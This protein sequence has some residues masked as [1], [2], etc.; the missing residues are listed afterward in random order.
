MEKGNIDT[1]YLVINHPE[2]TL[3]IM[4]GTTEYSRFA[5]YLDIL[6]KIVAN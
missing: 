1:R 2:I 5:S 6:L 4:K 3:Y